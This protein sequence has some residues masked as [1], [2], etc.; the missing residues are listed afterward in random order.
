M[1]HTLYRNTGV[2]EGFIEQHQCVP[3]CSYFGLTPV[4]EDEEIEMEKAETKSKKKGVKRKTR[5]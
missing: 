5:S 3:R 1:T 2:I 4:R